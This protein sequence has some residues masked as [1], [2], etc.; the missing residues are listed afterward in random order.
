MNR[1][2]FLAGC[3]LLL[4]ACGN[5]TNTA[6][7]SA[8]PPAAD[9]VKPRINGPVVMIRPGEITIQQV[10]I[11]TTQTYVLYSPVSIRSL[12][13]TEVIIFFD[14][15]GDGRLPVAKY[16][17]LAD[18]FGV[19]LVGSNSSKNGVDIS[20][21]TQYANN[22][23]NDVTKFF[24]YRATHICLAGFSGGA[25]VALNA[26]MNNSNI[27]NIIYTGASIPFN[28]RHPIH[29][30][31]FAGTEDMNYTDLLQ[32]TA[33]TAQSD[34]GVNQLIEFRGKHDWPDTL[35]FRKA[36]YWLSFAGCRQSA[37]TCDTTLVV[38]FKK[39]TDKDIALLEK[40]NASVNT[41]EE[42][43][44]AYSFLNGLTDVSSYK[45]KMDAMAGS[46][47]YKSQLDQ[48]NTMLQKEAQ[49]KQALLQAFQKQDAGWWYKTISGLKASDIASDK[50]LLGFISLA[51]YSYSGQLLSKGDT[52]DASKVLTIYE[53]ADPD[54][55]DQLYYHAQLYAMENNPEKATNYLSKAI[56]KGFNDRGKIEADPAF[57]QLRGYERFSRLLTSLK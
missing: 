20:V 18:R 7:M 55:T 44:M 30:L 6:E 17:K 45:A 37:A 36:F 52:V 50:R 39:E 25:K 9:S 22:I 33:T 11:D 38:R 23:I 57:T 3:F 19:V 49:S 5:K 29:L 32:F 15:H 1:I 47:A 56:K 40:M 21:T 16:Q 28:T 41:Y 43:R 24:D 42:C 14:P 54:N 13:S 8:N 4:A 27:S 34:P 2:I 26:G 51:S 48:K 10:S 35:T 31:G 12:D 53:L 46:Q